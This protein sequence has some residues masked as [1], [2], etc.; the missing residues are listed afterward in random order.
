M[1]RP[2]MPL[3]K[4]PG[5]GLTEGIEWLSTQLEPTSGHP[6]WEL[7]TKN[8]PQINAHANDA[9]HDVTYKELTHRRHAQLMDRSS[10]TGN[11]L[12]R[13]QRCTIRVTKMVTSEQT[14]SVVTMKSPKHVT[15]NR[16]YTAF[17]CFFIRQSTSPGHQR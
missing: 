5:V 6:P 17:R 11:K 3:T 14:E 1:D 13:A 2:D 15:S 10:L 4:L 8:T 12:K 7:S 9:K 16:A